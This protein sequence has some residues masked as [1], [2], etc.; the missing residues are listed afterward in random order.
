ME[1][2]N[3]F[4]YADELDERFHTES[5]AWETAGIHVNNWAWESHERAETAVYDAFLEKIAIEPD[6]KLKSCAENN[7]MGKRMFDKHLA[8]GDAYQNNAAKAA[9][10]GLA[11]A[12][13]RLAMILNDAVKAAN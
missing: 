9:E 4:R 5:A 3:P 11:E 6:L 12:G 1:V 8:V 10:T 2:S 13:I 7:H